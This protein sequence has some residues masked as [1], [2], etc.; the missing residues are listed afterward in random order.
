MKL[1]KLVFIII[2]YIDLETGNTRFFS[3]MINLQH[4]MLKIGQTFF[5]LTI[6]L[7]CFEKLPWPCFQLFA[8]L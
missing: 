4:P 8:A 6:P 7:L 5:S 3:R 2:N 1:N